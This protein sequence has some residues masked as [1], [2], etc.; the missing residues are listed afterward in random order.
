MKKLLLFLFFAA[1]ASGLILGNFTPA[2]AQEGDEFQ[3]EE[4]TVT[5]Q[6]RSENQQKVPIAMEVI[7]S[8]TIQDMG[9]TDITSILNNV[10]N[11]LIN[12]DGTTLRI[13]VRGVSADSVSEFMGVQ[14]RNPIVALNF[15]GVYSNRMDV[16][17]NMY[18]LERVE[19]LFG[20]QGTLY[21]SNT[22]GGIVNV[23]TGSPKLGETSASGTLEFGNYNRLHTEGKINAPVGDKIA[24]RGAFSVTDRKGY[25]PPGWDSEDVKSARLR[26]LLQPNERFSALLTLE[27]SR[28]QSTPGRVDVFAKQ[29]DV[30]DPW[31]YTTTKEPDADDRISKKIYANFEADLGFGILTLVPSYATRDYTTIGTDMSGY[32][33]YRESK[34]TEKS[35]ELRMSSPEEF[36]FTY[37]VGATYYKKKDAGDSVTPESSAWRNRHLLETS[38]FL[39]GN[40]TYPIT[41]RFRLTGGARLSDSYNEIDEYGWPNL[42]DPG[43]LEV[44]HEH[45]ELKYNDPNFKFGLEYDVNEKMMVY[46]DWSSSFRTHGQAYPGLNNRTEEL[47]AY[48]LGLKSRFFENKLQ[49]NGAAYYYDYRN[50]YLSPDL[51][52]VQYLNQGD[53]N[54]DGDFD[55]IVNGRPETMIMGDQTYDQC[56]DAKSYGLDISST[57]LFT[58]QD[59][60]DLSVSYSRFEFVDAF[61]DFQDATNELGFE[62]QDISGQQKPNS[63]EFTISGSYSH[64]FTL[65]NGG[66]L[67]ARVDSKWQSSYLLNYM[68]K[69]AEIDRMTFALTVHDITEIVQQEA[70]HLDNISLVYYDPSRKWTLTCYVNNIWNYAKKLGFQSMGPYALWIGPPRTYGAIFSVRY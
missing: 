1:V 2:N 22:P 67:T 56:Q 68:T 16:G 9:W 63:P 51:I 29:G 11:V 48:N 37:V 28:N 55:D 24:L 30:D 5:A 20:P 66:S 54:N 70:H 39:Y 34:F 38:K 57:M 50:Y 32:T 25:I 65:P 15:D 52:N 60:L 7:S 35:V 61:F 53:Y 6:K 13:G 33:Y 58:A 47:D 40:I 14:T 43:S 62:D 10:S 59:K 36:P 42:A 23:I 64:N 19:V 17:Q 49:L 27:Y 4:I 3:L 45:Q 12:K 8:E 18:D 21:A 41:D 46:T 31:T 26:A 44:Q 69:S